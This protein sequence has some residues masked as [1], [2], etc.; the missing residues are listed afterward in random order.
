MAA[1]VLGTLICVELSLS[2]EN[3]RVT[4]ASLDAR[5]IV[6]KTEILVPRVHVLELKFVFRRSLPVKLYINEE[7]SW[8]VPCVVLKRK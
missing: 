4:L 2:M 6:P 8:D 5:G 7:E 3:S 1:S